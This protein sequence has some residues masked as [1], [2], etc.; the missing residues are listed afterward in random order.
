ME[1]LL[2]LHAPKFVEQRRKWHSIP[3][4][5]R[6][7]L[8][9]QLQASIK[10]MRLQYCGECDI[11]TRPWSFI[12]GTDGLGKALLCTHCACCMGLLNV[13]VKVTATKHTCSRYNKYIPPPETPDIGECPAP[14]LWFTSILNRVSL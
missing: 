4:G 5:A 3:V 2:E 14:A 9:G 13:K 8:V 10:K 6:N 11:G 12:S 7:F 1:E